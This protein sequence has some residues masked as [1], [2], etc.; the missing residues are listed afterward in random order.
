M[1]LRK[2][3]ALLGSTGSIGVNALEVVRHF[4]DRFEILCLAAGRR[5][6]RLIEQIAEFRPRYVAVASEIELEVVRSRWDHRRHGGLP[7]MGSGPGALVACVDS[8]EV[9]L[10]ISALVGALGLPSTYRALELGKS[11]ALANK[12]TLVV[13]GELM[14]RKAKQSGAALIP[15]DSEHNALHQCLH[16]AKRAEVARLVL[17]ASGGPFRTLPLEEFDKITV[18]GALEHPTWVMGPKI[19]ID[20]ATLMNKGLEV[21]EAS[22]L[23]GF[24]PREI[25]VV[26]HPQSIV[27]SMIEFVDG[28]II[29]QLGVTD[30]RFAIQYALTFPERLPTP[31][32]RLDLAHVGK[33]EFERPDDQRFPCLQLAYEAMARS[34]T[35][36]AVLNACNEVA[37]Q[38]FLDGAIPFREIHPLIQKVLDQHQPAPV[39]SLEQLLSVD[40]WA[41]D[42]TRQWISVAVADGRA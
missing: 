18:A 42:V 4:R 9:D 30:M 23:F 34:G 36:P 19:T 16:G 29:A 10:V 32:P 38:A 21:I 12:E 1:G 31:L 3:I 17:T 28:S 22:W 20:S 35:A 13:A 40:T 6:D 37:V 11:V 14:M 25:D 41:R 5:V 7:A 27:H 26:I 8:P 2:R 33:L 15:I 39:E 24:S